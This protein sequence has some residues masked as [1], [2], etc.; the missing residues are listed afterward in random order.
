[1]KVITQLIRHF[2]ERGALTP[3][4]VEYLLRH[5]FV[6]AG[7]LAGYK[8]RKKP[9][10]DD[11]SHLRPV[12]PIVPPSNLEVVEE[13]L[14]RRGPLVRA[15]R[16]E[17]KSGVLAVDDIRHRLNAEFDRRE[18]DLDSV[19]ALGKRFDQVD[20]WRRAASEIHSVS[21]Q[22][23]HR[24]LCAELRGEDVLLGDL[25]QASDPE[26]WH[27][28]I[29][30]EEVRGRAAR[31]FVA[32]LTS[33]GPDTLGKYSWILKYDEMQAVINLRVLHE[34]LLESLRKIFRRDRLLLT[35]ALAKNSDPVQV[36]ALVLLYNAHRSRRLGDQP[37]Y[38]KEYGPVEPPE[39]GAW[40]HAWTAALRMDST[41]VTQLLVDCYRGDE[42]DDVGYG[43][44]CN[45]AL[46]C[47]VGWR[48][49]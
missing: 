45:R 30:D 12:V 27:L 5:D 22:R 3:L 31:S 2:W 35:Q 15:K 40:K 6:R 1:M 47:P 49:P 39:F 34:R 46:M 11:V 44:H 8:P 41:A 9:L 25:W 14:V 33:T 28:L 16:H 4:E 10:L 17:P 48:L 13:T 23:F 42:L 32:L 38:G 26:P 29:D 20:D 24:Q 36:W 19:L 18:H 7:D 43:M 37:D 21:Q